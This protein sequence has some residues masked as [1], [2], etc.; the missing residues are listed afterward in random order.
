MY[1]PKKFE[2]LEQY[3]KSQIDE[4]YIER[5]QAEKESI[6][7][8]WKAAWEEFCAELAQSD[9]KAEFVEITLLR[10]TLLQKD[11]VPIFLFEAFSERWLFGGLLHRK[12]VSFSTLTPMISDFRDAVYWEAKRY[13]GAISPQ[14][15]EKAFLEQLPY[16]ETC[17]SDMLKEEIDT[18]LFTSAFHSLFA[19]SFQCSFGGYRFF[20]NVLYKGD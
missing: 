10:H 7:E 14:L 11:D 13:M 6:C 4:V 9:F 5:L 19:Q 3:C 17:I 20:Q 18:W 16:M 8:E 12:K 1:L 2:Q 15:A